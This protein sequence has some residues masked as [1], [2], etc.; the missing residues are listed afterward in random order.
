MTN[1]M[2]DSG[3]CDSAKDCFFAIYVTIKG[4]KVCSLS[5]SHVQKRCIN[6]NVFVHMNMFT[7]V[8]FNLNVQ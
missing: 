8:S 1:F 2:L 6:F 7:L 5:E 4:S 3:V